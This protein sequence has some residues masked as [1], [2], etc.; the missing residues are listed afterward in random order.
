MQSLEAKGC[1][2]TS[3]DMRIPGF[4]EGKCIHIPGFLQLQVLRT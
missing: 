3:K 4:L 2:Q 1:R